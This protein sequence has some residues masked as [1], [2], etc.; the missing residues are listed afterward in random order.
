MAK[1]KTDAPPDAAAEAPAP[2]EKAAAEPKKPKAPKAAKDPKEP[3]AKPDAPAAPTPAATGAPP[4][5]PATPAPAAAPT[6]G[7]DKKKGNKPGVSPALG[8][9]LKGHLKNIKQK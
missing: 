4:A 6:E 3:K 1:K 2:E 7:G 9:K 8:K 5:A